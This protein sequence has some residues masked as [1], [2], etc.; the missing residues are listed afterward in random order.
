M[1]KFHKVCNIDYDNELNTRINKRYFPSQSLQ[2]NFSPVPSSTRYQKFMVSEKKLNND[3]L[4]QYPEFS[5]HNT[6]YPGSS[7]GPV[8]YKLNSVDVESNLRNQFFALQKNDQ[9]HYI[10]SDTSSL[11]V[12]DKVNE[13]P[14]LLDLC[15]PIQNMPFNPDRCNL[16]P[17]HF[18]NATRNNLKN[19]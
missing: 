1:R 15:E 3:N 10:P 8:S 11:Y 4:H 6:F 16:A 19:I 12:M 5:T 18:N 7:R 9:A 2:P 13:K 17:N 14:G